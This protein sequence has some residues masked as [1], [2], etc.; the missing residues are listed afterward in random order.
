LL[1]SWSVPAQTGLDLLD[2][3]AVEAEVG[4]DLSQKNTSKFVRERVGALR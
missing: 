2:Q 1:R 3:A 4:V